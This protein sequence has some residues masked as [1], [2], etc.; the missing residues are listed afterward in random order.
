VI[1]GNGTAAAS[2]LHKATKTIP[3]VFVLATDPVGLGIIESLAQPGGNM[4]GL[5]VIG[6]S[7]GSADPDGG[8][9]ERARQSF[10]GAGSSTGSL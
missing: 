6:R 1:V 5:R 7:N 8:R 4:T 10:S 9:D 3:V 2:E